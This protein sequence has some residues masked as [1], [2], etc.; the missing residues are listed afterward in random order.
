MVVVVFVIIILLGFAEV[1]NALKRDF[2]AMIAEERGKIVA[3]MK[4]IA[5]A[6]LAT[7]ATK[8]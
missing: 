2:S 4:D 5:A 6:L 3:K 8:R 7:E 1:D